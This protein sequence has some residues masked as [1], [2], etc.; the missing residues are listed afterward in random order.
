MLTKIK[1]VLQRFNPINSLFGKIIIW[2]WLSIAALMMTA[3][4]VSRL[5]APPIDVAQ[6]EPSHIQRIEAA[7][8]AVQALLNR[9][10]PAERALRRVATRGPWQLLLINPQTEETVLSFPNRLLPQER[11]IVQLAD[12]SQVLLITTPALELIGP[13]SMY[14]DAT[15]W[16]L[17]MVRLLRRDERQ[18]ASMGI[19]I[20]VVITLGTL[21]CLILAWRLTRPIEELRSVSLRYANGDLS[22]RVVNANARHD[23]IG[24]LANDFNT[25]A[26]KL[27][28]S[29]HQQQ[30]LMANVSHELRTPLTRLQLAVAMLQEQKVTAPEQYLA[31]I[32]QEIVQMDNLI[33]Q[34]LKLTRLENVSKGLLPKDSYSFDLQPINAVL[35][36]VVDSL[37]FE[38]NATGKTLTCSDIPKVEMR[39]HEDSIVSALENLARNAIRFAS[40]D[41][42]LDFKVEQNNLLICI[43]DDGKGL[44]SNDMDKLF[45]PFYRANNQ[46][47]AHNKG[48]GLGLAIAKAA[49]NLHHGEITVTCSSYGGLRLTMTLPI[50]DN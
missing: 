3:L 27:S 29:M 39:M 10:V 48:S 24:Q 15:E 1:T 13:L 9:G 25:M 40:S 47:V 33:G 35:S 12:A 43:D 31:R 30:M 22:S 32:E 36:P 18:P 20:A 34:I 7:S 42:Y 4:V 16:K 37:E 5:V 46:G 45:D 6:P 2:F 28:G 14:Q 44:D 23:E 17:F 19:S 50:S 38:A 11:S 26:D 41:V 21:L 49:V 8:V